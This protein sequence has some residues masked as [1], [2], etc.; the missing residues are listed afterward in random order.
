MSVLGIKFPNYEVWGF[1]QI[2]FASLEFG[3]VLH[4]WLEFQDLLQ[5]AVLKTMLI[6]MKFNA[7]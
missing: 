3:G 2:I 6:G 7:C 5:N 4:H 1:V